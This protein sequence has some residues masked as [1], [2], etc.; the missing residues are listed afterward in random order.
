MNLL[1]GNFTLK[2]RESKECLEC[3]MSDSDS[4][5]FF[6]VRR[7]SAFCASLCSA[8]RI[9]STCKPYDAFFCTKSYTF[10]QYIGIIGVEQYHVILLRPRYTQYWTSSDFLMYTCC[11]LLRASC[12]LLAQIHRTVFCT[13]PRSQVLHKVLGTGF[14]CN[15]ILPM[16]ILFVMEIC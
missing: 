2:R 7:C 3:P 1:H 8:T 6:P 5:A 9:L 4:D 14:H 13:K 15:D 12:L 11:Q 16:R 10:L